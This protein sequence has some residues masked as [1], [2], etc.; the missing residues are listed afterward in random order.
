VRIFVSGS[1]EVAL[2][3]EAE[4]LSAMTR[5]VGLGDLFDTPFSS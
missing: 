3:R 4:V 2:E 5:V 1:P